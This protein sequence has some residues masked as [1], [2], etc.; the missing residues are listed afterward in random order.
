MEPSSTPGCPEPASMTVPEAM[1]VGAVASLLVTCMATAVGLLLRYVPPV[2]NGFILIAIII[3][4]WYLSSHHPE[5]AREIGGRAVALLREAS[6][7]LSHR[8]MTAIRRQS[9]QVG[10]PI[11]LLILIFEFQV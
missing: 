10:Y 3:I 7:A 11:F 1:A 4:V 9:D 8:V 2:A 6:L 5:T